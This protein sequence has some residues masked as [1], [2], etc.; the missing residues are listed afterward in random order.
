MI[1][2]LLLGFEE[3]QGEKLKGWFEAGNYDIFVA[4]SLEEGLVCCQRRAPELLFMDVSEPAI[5]G[6]ELFSMLEESNLNTPVIFYAEA[7]E[8]DEVINAFR[9]GVLDF[10]T[11]SELNQS[12]IFAAFAKALEK[13]DGPQRQKGLEAENRSLRSRFDALNADQEAGRLAQ[14]KL[15]PET[16]FYF[17][18]YRFSHHIIPSL[19]LSGDFIDYFEI[20]E[21]EC[22]F[23]LADVS[24]HGASS[25]FITVLLKCLMNDIRKSEPQAEGKGIRSPS[26]VLQRLNQELVHMSLSK[27]V[28]ML[29]GVINRKNST[30]VYSVAAHYPLP[31]LSDGK[32]ARFIGAAA[33]PLGVLAGLNVKEYT[34]PLP[35]AFSLVMFTD[36][37]MGVLPQEG[38][39]EKEQGLLEML[40][41]ACT[42][43]PAISKKLALD[44]IKNPD[45]DIGILVI[46]G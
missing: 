22:G 24:G 8:I 21:D 10:L 26:S 39:L 30:L 44:G 5:G 42:S 2:V 16:P 32:K 9:R 37:I 31:I 34:E 6:L 13:V 12:N 35:E 33:L 36:G 25:A 41:T 40:D 28:A 38:L 18:Q 11:G 7:P 20:D 29:Y 19:L 1:T 27:H 45:D 43:L 46:E 4:T 23:Y 17:K 14:L 15:F 3:V